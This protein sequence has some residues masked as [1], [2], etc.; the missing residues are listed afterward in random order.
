MLHKTVNSARQVTAKIESMIR[1]VLSLDQTIWHVNRL[2]GEID[3][4]LS[5]V[6]DLVE[7]LQPV[8]EKADLTLC[9]VDTTIEELGALTPTLGNIV[10]QVGDVV[11]TFSPAFAV[12]DVVRRQLDRIRLRGGD[13]V[14]SVRITTISK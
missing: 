5:K 4:A 7:V 6:N 1:A 9:Q 12:N 3:I 8:L 14:E 11:H 2:L 13:S 10:G